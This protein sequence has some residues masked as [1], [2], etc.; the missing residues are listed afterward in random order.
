M[1]ITTDQIQAELQRIEREQGVRVLFAAESGSRAWGFASRDS[2]HDVRF[3]YLPTGAG[4]CAAPGRREVI[5]VAAGGL[6]LV[7]WSLRKALRQ[8]R[9]SDPT[10]LEWIRSP[11]V[12]RADAA[13]ALLFG[14]LA[15]ELSS[16]AR[17][18]G[19]SLNL[20]R[21]NHRALQGSP[22][23]LKDYLAML[24]PLLA[25]RWIERGLG[26]VPMKFQTLVD[27]LVEEANLRFHIAVLVARKRAGEELDEAQRIPI[28]DA[29]LATELARLE[30]IAP[31]D[32]ALPAPEP[33]DQ[34]VRE[35][36]LAEA[37]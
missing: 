8:L 29:F 1:N 27:D 28:L 37:A 16:G 12:F 11:V 33:I 2:D 25:C 36:C 17:S 23:R 26:P 14:L 24:R 34:F 20:A 3:I 21:I 9:E 18:F 31:A 15:S 35:F 32:P 22:V 30:K 5:E 13:F 10:L 4:D 6:D 19:H 7:G